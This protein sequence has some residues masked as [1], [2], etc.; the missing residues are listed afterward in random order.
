MLEYDKRLVEIDEILNYLS[1]ADL[2]KIP[3][4]V[5]QAIKENKNNEYV[6][7]YDE[8]KPLKEQDISRDTIILLSYLNMEYLLNEKQK[9]LM[10]QI[11]KENEKKVEVQQEQQFQYEDLFKKANNNQNTQNENEEASLTNYKETFFTKLKKY[12]LKFLHI[13]H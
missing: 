12:I 8:T 11:H 13:K 9:E 2:E 10:E 4:D 5:R 7:K 3:E 6:W 1:K